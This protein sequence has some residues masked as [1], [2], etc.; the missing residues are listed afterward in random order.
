MELYGTPLL[1]EEEQD[2]VQELADLTLELMPS[3]PRYAEITNR[4][5]N[6]LTDLE[7]KILC[8]KEEVE[9]L[10]QTVREKSQTI[11]NLHWANDDHQMGGA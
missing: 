11:S 7:T 9:V 2:I 8:L 5:Y 6:T 4:A 1:C 3:H 10:E